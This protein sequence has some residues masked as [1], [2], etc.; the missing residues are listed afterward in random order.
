MRLRLQ[1]IS[2]LRCVGMV[3]GDF[4]KQQRQQSAAAQ[5]RYPT[6]IRVSVTIVQHKEKL[7]CRLFDVA[8]P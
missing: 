8:A 2:L 7:L 6:K 5:Q 4:I 3:V 1:V